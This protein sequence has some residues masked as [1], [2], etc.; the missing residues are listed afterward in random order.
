MSYATTANRP[1]PLAAIGALGVPAG[2]GLVLIAGLAVKIVVNP[3]IPNPVATDVPTVVVT[4]EPIVD[5]LP[6]TD[7]QSH[8]APAPVPTFTRPS[9]DI[10]FGL[11]PTGPI[12]PIGDFDT[13]SLIGSDAFTGTLPPI[14]PLFDPVDASPRSNPSNWITTNDYRSSWI[15]RELTGKARFTLRID[16]SG[17]VSDCTITG[18]TGH[19][20]LDRATCMLIQQRAVFNP[21]KDSDGMATAGTYS[22]SVNWQIP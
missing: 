9:S 17:K 13:G 19:T 1:N 14:E 6:P 5:P 7:P 21:A 2:V 4:P 15:R 11:S 10:E 16:A 12:G 20:P 8:A 18:S 22:S 3:P